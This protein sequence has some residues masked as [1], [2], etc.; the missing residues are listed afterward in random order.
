MVKAYPNMHLGK[1]WEAHSFQE[2]KAISDQSFA[3]DKAN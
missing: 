3:D 2:F 1:N